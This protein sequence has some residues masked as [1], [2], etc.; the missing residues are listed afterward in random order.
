MSIW[1]AQGALA[2]VSQPEF[3]Y[4]PQLKHKGEIA[5]MDSVHILTAV[6]III[7]F[8]QAVMIMLL[9]GLKGDIKDLWDRIYNHYHLIGCDNKACTALHTGSVVIPQK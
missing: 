7:G 2:N 4:E 3:V 9:L 8:M 6:G 1:G 5:D